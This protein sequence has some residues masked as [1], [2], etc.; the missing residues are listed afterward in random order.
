MPKRNIPKFR[1]IGTYSDVK[2]PGIVTGF[3]LE[4]KNNGAKVKT[5]VYEALQLVPESIEKS[6]IDNYV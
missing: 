1:I 6:D 5:T 2:N 3:L 4:D